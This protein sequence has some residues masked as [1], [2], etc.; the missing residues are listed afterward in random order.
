VFTHDQKYGF[1]IILDHIRLSNLSIYNEALLLA[2]KGYGYK[3][4]TKMLCKKYNMRINYSTVYKWIHNL[5]SPLGRYNYPEISPD[6]SYVI[7]AWLGDGTLAYRKSKHEYIVKL[8][9]KDYDFAKEWGRRLSRAL[10]RSRPYK[11]VWDKTNKRWCV[12]GY[13]KIL[14]LLLFE[15]R[16]NLSVIKEIVSSYPAEAIRGF[17]DAEGSVINNPPTII[18]CNTRLDIIILFKKT[19]IKNFY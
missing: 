6:L 10:Q 7:G 3:K 4:I 16:R 14:Y 2:S 1:R 5:N 11:P 13:S 17:F 9:V 18:A 19:I 15:T 12:R 8:L